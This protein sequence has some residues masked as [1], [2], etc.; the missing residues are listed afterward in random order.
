MRWRVDN[1]RG[2][3]ALMLTN[4]RSADGWVAMGLPNRAGAMGPSD[5]YIGFVSDTNVPVVSDRQVLGSSNNYPVVDSVYSV[6]QVGGERA[7]GTISVWF[8]RDLLATDAQDVSLGAGPVPVIWAYHRSATPSDSTADAFISKHSSHSIDDITINF[9]TGAVSTD[10]LR[11]K[12]RRAH[13]WLMSVAWA[14]LV[15]V[16]IIVARFY[17]DTLGVWWFRLHA[18][19]LTLC[20]A[21]TVAGFGMAVWFTR[22][23]FSGA[24][25][26]HKIAG[27]AITISTVLQCLLG[28]VADRLWT[29]QRAATPAVPDKLH[30]WYGRVLALAALAN[31]F[32]GLIAYEAG[33]A[34]YV[35]VGVVW[36]ALLVWGAVMQFVRGAVHH[37]NNNN[38]NKVAPGH[39]LSTSTSSSSELQED[40]ARSQTPTW[41]S[42]V[43][44]ASSAT[45]AQKRVA[46]ASGAP[47]A[48][49]SSAS[50]ASHS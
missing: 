18:A 30:W 14:L 42:D 20:L 3:L 22:V 19:L 48:S 29:P 23:H 25:A 50:A 39:T 11:A 7:A 21:M 41:A 49:V 5:V 1:A 10:T 33:F 40:D 28:I 8:E 46:S 31:C 12:L 9:V 2:T 13:G 4:L 27:L 47:S 38:S 17:K 35:L 6:R 15:P 44:S 37:N 24:N 43:T 26:T 36:G 32:L 45:S 16:A 34:W